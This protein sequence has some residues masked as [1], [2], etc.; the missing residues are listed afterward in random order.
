LVTIRESLDNVDRWISKNPDTPNELP[1]PSE[2]EINIDYASLDRFIVG[3]K[4]RRK[5]HN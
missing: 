5:G 1:H 4:K 3:W 2:I